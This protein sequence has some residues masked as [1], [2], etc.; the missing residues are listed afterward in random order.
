MEAVA[1]RAGVLQAVMAARNGQ[2][3]QA[4]TMIDR[5]VDA[6]TADRQDKLNYYNTLLNFYG[7]QK[8]VEQKKLEGLTGD[9]KKYIDAQIGQLEEQ[10]SIAEKNAQHIKD[11]MMSPD[12]AQAMAFSGVTLLDNPEEVAQ[13]LAKY[14]YTK[15]IQ[16]MSKSMALKGYTALLPGGTAP[17]GAQVVSIPFADPITG[18]TLNQK[19]YLPAEAQKPLEVSA[20]SSLYDPITGEYLGTAPILDKETGLPVAGGTGI[21]QAKLPTPQEIASATA[22]SKLGFELLKNEEGMKQVVGPIQGRIPALRGAGADFLAK[23]NSLI[24]QE[25]LKNMGLIKGV[26]S[27]SDM[28]LLKSAST[29]GLSRISTEETFKKTLQGMIG[30]SMAIQLAPKL[31][32]ELNTNDLAWLNDDESIYA[33]KN[34]DGT[35]H[36]GFKDDGYT[37]V[38]VAQ[39][40]GFSSVGGGTNNA[41][42]SVKLGSNLAIKNNNPGNL[43]FIGQPGATQGVGGFARF[44]SPQAGAMALVQ[45]IEAKKAPGGSL[46]PQSTL[47]QFVN[48][49]AP[50]SENDTGLYIQQMSQRL[51]VSPSTPISKINTI[52]LAK[53]IAKKES[54]SIIA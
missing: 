1:A 17:V 15:E 3:S 27:D 14:S 51:G 38:T 11:L 5:S 28:A 52:A 32:Q 48:V 40:E 50:P 35:L 43:R 18:K 54:S 9:K 33:Y 26:L 19:W 13:K 25:T 42:T 24:G 20:G 39:Q 30:A 6:I 29:G 37:D 47:A 23:L 49:Y 21:G 2:I 4:Y 36:V 34:N 44:S 7:D 46:G 45:D 22:I 12:T 10:V 16:D 8:G 41:F 31:Q 53:E